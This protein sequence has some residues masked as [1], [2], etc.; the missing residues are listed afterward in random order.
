MLPH[1]ILWLPRPLRNL[2]VLPFHLN[3]IDNLVPHGVRI[4]IEDRHRSLNLVQTVIHLTVLQWKNY[5]I[6]NQRFPQLQDMKSTVNLAKLLQKVESIRHLA[7]PGY[8][9]ERTDIPWAQ[10]VML[11]ESYD[12]FPSDTFRRTISPT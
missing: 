1:L 10:L 6:I 11:P 8:N 7:C 5:K 2:A 12:T 3:Q 4:H 9:P